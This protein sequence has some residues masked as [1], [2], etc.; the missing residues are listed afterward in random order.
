M[1]REF[2]LEVSEGFFEIM[3][4]KRS[5]SLGEVVMVIHR[6]GGKVLLMTKPFYPP[7][8]YRLPSGQIM[9]GESPE[10]AFVRELEE[11]TGISDTRFR[12]LDEL[13]FAFR[14]VDS[15][16]DYPSHLFTTEETAR[17]PEPKDAEETITGFI[18]IP[19]CDL[20]NIAESLANLSEPWHDWGQFRSLPHR[21]AY[22]HLCLEKP[23][24]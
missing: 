23:D 7:G 11:E 21:I 20:K 14:C 5:A 18:E 6:P 17:K 9:P 10:E 12:R 19:V 1:T 3:K 16:L 22:E 8:I 2:E 4:A 24:T 13:R 15:H